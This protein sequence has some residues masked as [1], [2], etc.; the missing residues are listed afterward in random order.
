MNCTSFVAIEL[1][2]TSLDTTG[3]A[4]AK[5]EGRS[6]AIG[7]GAVTVGKEPYSSFSRLGL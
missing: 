3:R 2:V 7:V 5:K 6:G 4:F 1:P